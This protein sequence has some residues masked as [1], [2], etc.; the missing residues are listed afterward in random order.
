MKILVIDDNTRHQASA[1]QTLTDHDLTVAGSWDEAK[2]HLEPQFDEAAIA[3]KLRAQN[4]PATTKDVYAARL[5][6]DAWTAWWDAYHAAKL[7]AQLPYWDAVLSDMMLPASRETMGGDG[8]KFIGQEMPLGFPL[9]LMA[10]KHG[11]KF[12]AVATETNHHHHPFSA[13]IDSLG[14]LHEVNGAK[15]SFVHAP[16]TQVEGTVCD[17]CKGTKVRTEECYTCKGTCSVDGNP[18]DRCIEGKAKC[19]SCDGT[20]LG[21]GKDWGKILQGLLGE[22]TKK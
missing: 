4:L 13:A 17:L 16:T 20:G 10:S 18:C 11:A 3:E 7:A 6:G 9:V 5:K 19:Y 15:A 22:E 1:R 21:S 2:K 12:V 8:E 14:G